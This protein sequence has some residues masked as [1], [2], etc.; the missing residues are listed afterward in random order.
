MLLALVLLL[1][2]GAGPG[3]AQAGSAPTGTA[4]TAGA[5]R[6]T[7]PEQAGGEGTPGQQAPPGAG[8]EALPPDLPPRAEGTA[9]GDPPSASPADPEEQ[10]GSRR[11]PIEPF[12]Y[13]PCCGR[14]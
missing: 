11:A 2:C 9:P 7:D 1:A 10:G 12:E 14:R 13:F 3:A 4:L 5:S 8:S 6:S